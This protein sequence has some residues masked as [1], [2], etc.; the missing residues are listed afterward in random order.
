MEDVMNPK[1]KEKL[2]DKQKQ[3]LG[4]EEGA[5]IT[6]EEAQR[7]ALTEGLPIEF[8]LKDVF[9][10]TGKKIKDFTEKAK[11]SLF[12]ARKFLPKVLRHYKK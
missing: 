3:E 9:L 7:K 8:T 4:I 6:K 10:P 11:K 2:T 1:M 5:K 12:T